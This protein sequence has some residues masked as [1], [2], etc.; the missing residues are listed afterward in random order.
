MRIPGI[1]PGHAMTFNCKKEIFCEVIAAA[2]AAGGLRVLSTEP[3]PPIEKS[4]YSKYINSINYIDYLL[5]AFS[6]FLLLN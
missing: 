2:A 6:M 4:N 3:N 1:E 5:V